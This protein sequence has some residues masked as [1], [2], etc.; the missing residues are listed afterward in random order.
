MKVLIL[1]MNMHHVYIIKDQSGEVVYVGVSSNIPLRFKSHRIRFGAGS[2]I[3]ILY[4]FKTR[5]KALKK[6]TKVIQLFIEK[7]MP[8]KN[9]H[10]RTTDKKVPLVIYVRQSVIDSYGGRKAMKVFI[11][12]LLESKNDNLKIA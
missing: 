8:L 1:L 12:N 11:E 3:E 2:K 7:E 10:K 4:S 9:I 5:Q 6:E